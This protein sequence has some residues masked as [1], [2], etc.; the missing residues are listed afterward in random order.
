LAVSLLFGD[1]IN[2]VRHAIP[3][4]VHGTRK[5]LDGETR[6]TR[7]QRAGLRRKGW[8]PLAEQIR[9]EY[10]EDAAASPPASW[11]SLRFVRVRERSSG[12]LATETKRN[13]IPVTKEGN[14]RSGAVVDEMYATAISCLVESLPEG[15]ARRRRRCGHARSIARAAAFPP[16]RSQHF[17]CSR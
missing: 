3:V 14:A 5:M 9:Q 7:T 2:V 13:W 8:L 17:S 16:A 12:R 6:S 11:K 10:L 1:R 15:N 4:G